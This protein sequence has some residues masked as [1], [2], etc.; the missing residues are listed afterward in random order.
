MTSK[1]IYNHS[2]FDRTPYTYLIGWIDVDL[3]YYGR[4]T[5]EG[6]HPEELFISYFTSSKVVYDIRSEFG[7]PDVIRTH[8]FFSE[9]NERACK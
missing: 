5:A 9:R 7:E 8:K 2:A 6:C 1:T 3:W 4:R